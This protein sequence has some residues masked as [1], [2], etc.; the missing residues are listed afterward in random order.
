MLGPVGALPPKPH[1][2]LIAT[3]F[4]HTPLSKAQHPDAQSALFEQGPVRNCV[5][6]CAI[7]CEAFCQSTLAFDD[8][9]ELTLIIT[10]TKHE[11]D[12]DDEAAW[13]ENRHGVVEV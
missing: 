7:A 3:A 5:P 1:W 8:W 4:R 2:L 9:S 10:L 12:S 13:S 6:H 11:G